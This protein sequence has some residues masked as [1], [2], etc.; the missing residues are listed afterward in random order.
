M[1]KVGVQKKSKHSMNRSKHCEKVLIDFIQ[2][3]RICTSNEFTYISE[4]KS[5]RADRDAMKAQAENLQ[6][7]YDRLADQF[8]EQ[9]Q[10]I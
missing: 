7:E 5:M 10:Y 6:I 2:D 8:A 1:T 4:L 9:V 3:S